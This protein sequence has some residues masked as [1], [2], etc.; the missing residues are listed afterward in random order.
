MA[1]TPRSQDSLEKLSE[2][3]WL[4]AYA[5]DITVVVIAMTIGVTTWQRLSG[6]ELWITLFFCVFVIGTRQ[7][8]LGVLGHDGA[9]GLISRNRR[10]NNILTNMAL[11]PLGALSEGY[12]PFH[13]KHLATQYLAPLGASF[14]TR[15]EIAHTFLQPIPLRRA[16]PTSRKDSFLASLQKPHPGKLT[17]VNIPTTRPLAWWFFLCPSFFSKKSS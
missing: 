7:H 10:V 4:L 8:G 14:L 3:R 15:K 16:L 1:T 17:S 13:L 6:P 11:L 9:H 5:S 12:R 2:T